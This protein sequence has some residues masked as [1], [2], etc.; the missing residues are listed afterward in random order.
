MENIQY[1]DNFAKKICDIEPVN[2][3]LF[4][5]D[6]QIHKQYVTQNIKDKIIEFCFKELPHIAAHYDKYED[7]YFLIQDRKNKGVPIG[8]SR[9]LEIIKLF[10]EY[11]PEQLEKKG[12]LNPIEISRNSLDSQ[13]LHK[14]LNELFQLQLFST[15]EL[16]DKNKHSE[17]M[18]NLTSVCFMLKKMYPRALDNLISHLEINP[19][20]EHFISDLKK[21]INNPSA[22]Q[23][24]DIYKSQPDFLKKYAKD[25][26]AKLPEEKQE[27]ALIG[28][29]FVRPDSERKNYR[30]LNSIA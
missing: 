27:S 19:I 3:P 17:L 7:R 6:N 2:T 23:I 4:S 26:I 13:I 30:S 10:E 20:M 8:S 15:E 12:V 21:N 24:E 14:S 9:D 25:L 11:L 16:G 28:V 5:I 1:I 29:P 18:T 22:E